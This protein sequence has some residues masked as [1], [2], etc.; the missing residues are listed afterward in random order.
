MVCPCSCHLIMENDSWEVAPQQFIAGDTLSS[1]CRAESRSPEPMT[2]LVSQ[3][4]SHGAVGFVFVNAMWCTFVC[5]R[6]CFPQ[7]PRGVSSRFPRSCLGILRRHGIGQNV[8]LRSGRLGVGHT[9]VARADTY[10][11]LYL[12]NQDSATT[13]DRRT[14][15]LW[16]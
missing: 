3:I 10:Q 16:R 6:G 9:S 13:V 5:Q 8:Y 1:D 14:A 4:A 2:S 12:Q 11:T 15:N 7:V